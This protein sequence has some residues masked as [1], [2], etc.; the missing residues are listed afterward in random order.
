[1]ENKEIQQAHN[2]ENGKKHFNKDIM[3]M[4]AAIA[5]LIIVL[6]VIKHLMGLQ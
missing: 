5:G 2:E 4:I 6:L 3:L 1:M